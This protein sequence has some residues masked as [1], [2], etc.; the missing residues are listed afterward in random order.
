MPLPRP[1][2]APFKTMILTGAFAAV[3]IVGA[4]YGAGLKTQEEIKQEKDKIAE[5]SIEDRIRDLEARRSTLVS[6]RIPLERKLDGLRARMRAQ[7]QEGKD[8]VVEGD[9]K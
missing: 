7:A 8:G 6:Q 4:I 1:Q 9:G 2:R 3:A 5:A